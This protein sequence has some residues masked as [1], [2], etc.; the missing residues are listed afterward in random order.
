MAIKAAQLLSNATPACCYWHC[1]CSCC[2]SCLMMWGVCRFGG[3]LGLV[4][5]LGRGQGGPGRAERVH[6]CQFWKLKSDLGAQISTKHGF[7]SQGVVWGAQENWEASMEGAPRFSNAEQGSPGH[8][9]WRRGKIQSGG[10][11]KK[12]LAGQIRLK[13]DIVDTVFHALSATR[14]NTY[15]QTPFPLSWRNSVKGTT[16]LE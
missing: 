6:T 7:L 2:C 11:V 3:L 16:V 10:F 8:G 1:C 9:G 14:H 5:V 15:K 12:R 4:R 13:R